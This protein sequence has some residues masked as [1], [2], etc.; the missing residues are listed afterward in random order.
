MK[1]D[2]VK[3][4]GYWKVLVM[5]TGARIYTLSLPRHGVLGRDGLASVCTAL[6]SLR[7]LHQRGGL[8][9]VGTCCMHFYKPL[10]PYKYI[11]NIS[12]TA[13]IETG[14]GRADGTNGETRIVN[15]SKYQSQW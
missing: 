15:L 12:A 1:P 6:L 4:T 7:S 11:H 14:S 3:G 10:G 8:A 9:L 2:K 5:E 13:S